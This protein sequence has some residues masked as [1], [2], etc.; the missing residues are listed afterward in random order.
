MDFKTAYQRLQE[1]VVY[2]KSN[3][4]IDIEELISLQEEA[5]ILYDFLQTKLGKAHEPK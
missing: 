3:Q 2:I 1:I 5:K 4:I